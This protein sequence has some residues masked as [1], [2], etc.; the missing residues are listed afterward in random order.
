MGRAVDDGRRDRPVRPAVRV[1]LAE[2][3]PDGQHRPDGLVDVRF[4][5]HPLC[6]GR[7]DGID[8][9]LRVRVVDGEAVQ[10]GL[11]D[12]GISLGLRS[13][14]VLGPGQV[15]RRKGI[16]DVEQRLVGPASLDAVQIRA[17]GVGPAVHQVVG[18]HHAGCRIR[19]Y[20]RLERRTVVLVQHPLG[21]VRRR[22]VATGLV[23]VGQVVL[24]RRGGLQVAR[25]VA[26]H[27]RAVRRRDGAREHRV[28]RVALLVAA[29]PRITQQ[30][31]DGR[32]EI[33]APHNGIL[34]IEAACFVAD[35]GAD[36]LDQRGVPGAGQP[37]R[38]REHR[39]VR[40]NHVP[41][42]VEV[43]RPGDA[44]QCLGARLEV[45]DAQTRDRPLRLVQQRD[46]LVQGQPP[47]QVVNP[48]VER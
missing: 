30:V 39:A 14:V 34:R 16:R 9:R 22:H 10:P 43:V 15:V 42:V 3:E 24:Q 8:H 4:G 12:R 1:E 44:V 36:L 28:L 11:E 20:R 18:T 40:G 33:Q 27:A 41:V 46:L 48:R 32:P 35:R 6:Q 29:P 47:E 21:D 45:R 2:P 13:E 19:R 5:Q 7:L 37:D 23:V 25:V 38:L 31:H 26:L 17:N